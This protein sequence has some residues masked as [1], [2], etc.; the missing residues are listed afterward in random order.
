M[1]NKILHMLDGENESQCILRI[2]SMK[3]QEGWTWRDIADILNEVLGHNYGE[4][5]YRK[6]FQQ[7]NRMLN[8][9]DNVIFSDDEYLKQIRTEKEE[10]FKAKKQFQ[11]QRRE[12]NKILTMDARSDHLVE[13]LIKVAQSLNV[14][15]Q[16]G[17]NFDIYFD[18]NNDA[19][20]CLTDWHF[21][22]VTDNIWNKFNVDI[23]IERINTLCEKSKAY[24]RLHNVN[25]LHVL[26]LG[27]FIH[28]AIHSTAR[29]ASEE[30]TSDQLMHVSELIA[31]LVDELSSSVNEV[32]VY[33]TYG[34]HARTVQDKKESVHSDN[35]EKIISW[36]LTWRLKDSNKIHI[37]N[38]NYY[39]FIYLNV[40]GHEI[41]GVHGDLDNFKTIGID[42]HT[43]FHKQYGFDIEYVFSGDKHHMNELDPYGIE[44]TLVRSLCGSDEYANNKRLYSKAGQTLCIFNKKDGKVC[45]YNI[46][47]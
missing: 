44:C 38:N 24:L 2:C 39:E 15:K 9:M 26:L 47:F 16:I 11:D 40:L 18:A 31:E 5:A 12:Y 17:N 35:M 7:F 21:G 8:D 41:I 37:M 20:L 43:L 19:V 25:K 13:E 45:E 23:C 36:W 30:E 3:E 46:T 1:D 4:S 27:D 28:G 33:S 14:K 29:V 42:M 34:N 22:M 32:Y 6:K 10:L